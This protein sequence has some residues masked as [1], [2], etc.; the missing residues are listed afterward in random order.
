MEADKH[1]AAAVSLHWSLNACSYNEVA[2]LHITQG[3]VAREAQ[4]KPA[5]D[6]LADLQDNYKLSVLEV[7]FD[8]ISWKGLAAAHKAAKQDAETIVLTYLQF[9]KAVK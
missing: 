7:C 1:A 5:E 2:D 4:G 9:V 8:K 6:D 3:L